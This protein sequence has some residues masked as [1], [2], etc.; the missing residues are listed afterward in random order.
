MATN[1]RI[2]RRTEINSKAAVSDTDNIYFN[3]ATKENDAT[4]FLKA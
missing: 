1:M 2:Y 3:E 4:Q